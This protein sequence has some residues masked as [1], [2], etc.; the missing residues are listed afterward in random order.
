MTKH[1][2]MP[3]NNTVQ[4]SSP[5]RNSRS[6]LQDAG[7]FTLRTHRAARFWSAARERR[8]HGGE[9][10]IRRPNTS[11]ANTNRSLNLRTIW[12]IQR[13]LVLRS[14][15]PVAVVRLEREPS[16]RRL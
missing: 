8:F 16:T 6:A 1:H 13:L 2:E 10:T 11:G 15:C 4:R 12:G 14:D 5:K 7:A 3:P 9:P